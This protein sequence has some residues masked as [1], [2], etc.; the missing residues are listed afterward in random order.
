MAI[1]LITHNLGVVAQFSQDVIVM[2]ASKIAERASVEELFKHPSHPYTK[3]TPIEIPS[4]TW[5]TWKAIGINHKAPCH[6]LCNIPRDVISPL[7]V[8]R[9]LR[10]VRTSLLR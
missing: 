8:R 7:V 10:T 1:L 4:S 5:R 2:Y 9:F 3:R 6:L